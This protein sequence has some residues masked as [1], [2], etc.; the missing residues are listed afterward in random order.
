M[1]PNTPWAR[2]RAGYLLQRLPCLWGTNAAA[3]WG[4]PVFAQCLF[5]N[6]AAGEQSRLQLGKIPYLCSAS[7]STLQL[8]SNPGCNLGK[9]RIC[10]APPSRLCSWGTI[11]VNE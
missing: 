7:F 2:R 9:S 4:N 1:R 11:A 5:L 10:A 3:T 8:G 6:S